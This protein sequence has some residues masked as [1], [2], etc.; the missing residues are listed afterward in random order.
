MLNSPISSKT[1]DAELRA[2]VGRA[3]DT[4]LGR[5]PLED[6]TLTLDGTGPNGAVQLVVLRAV[7]QERLARLREIHVISASTFPFLGELALS[8]GEHR[9][10]V[11]DLISGWDRATRKCHSASLTRYLGHKALGR[12]NRKPLFRGNTLSIVL[13]RIVTDR[14]AETRVRDLGCNAV[15]WLYDVDRKELVRVDRDGD[16]RDATLDE[17]AACSCAVPKLYELG[18]LAG[19]RF[20]DP[21]YSPMYRDLIK[22]LREA[23][24]NHLFANVIKDRTTEREIM[25]KNH[26]FGDGH[27]MMRSDFLRLAMNRPNQRVIDAHRVALAE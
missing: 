20:I 17:V 5:S 10:R 26:D 22:S 16:L 9:W 11:D 21:V 18:R 23:S 15:F 12:W 2:R 1:A 13:R 4:F 6:A 8:A 27:E 25:L 3:V 19:R 14:F 7:G 24:R